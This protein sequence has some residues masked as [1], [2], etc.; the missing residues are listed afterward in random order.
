[1]KSRQDSPVSGFTL[2][3]QACVSSL[4]SSTSWLIRRRHVTLEPGERLLVVFM[5]TDRCCATSCIRLLLSVVGTATSM[6][7]HAYSR[8]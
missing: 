8:V 6:D 2:S 7:R 3:R 1:M 5:V 4:W